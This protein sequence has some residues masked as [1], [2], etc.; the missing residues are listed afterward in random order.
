MTN[1]SKL[2]DRVK[3][4]AWALV[5]LVGVLLVNPI[6]FE[7]GAIT[8]AHHGLVIGVATGL[9]AGAFVGLILTLTAMTRSA[10][11]RRL[12]PVQ[13]TRFVLGLYGAALCF[14]AGMAIEV[15]GGAVRSMFAWP[16]TVLVIVAAVV[17]GA[18]LRE[19]GLRQADDWN[20]H[21]IQKS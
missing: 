6:A 4:I 17:I 5:F 15:I 19:W 21:G 11:L 1:T 7:L 12:S 20:Q 9:F 2:V 3:L 13:R 10:D 18:R 14:V 16:I 8:V